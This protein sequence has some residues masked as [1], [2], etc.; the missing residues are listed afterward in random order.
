MPGI[1][2]FVGEHTEEEACTLLARMCRAL[3]DG[4]RLQTDGY[5]APGVGLGRLRFEWGPQETQPL[6]SEDGHFCLLFEGE[7]YG[8]DDRRR[9]LAA[10]GHR[11]ETGTDAEYVL[12]LYETLGERFLDELNGAFIGAIWHPRSRRLVLFNDHLGQRPLYYASVPGGLCFASGIRA[13]LE[14]PHVEPAIDPLGLAQMLTFE[15]L[16]ED[17][18]LLA[19]VRLLAPGSVLVFEDGRLESR[20][21][22]E[23]RF[24]PANPSMDPEDY[25]QGFVEHIRRA[26]HRQLSEAD[27]RRV[28][29]L[30][31]GGL[32]SR[33][34]LALLH[35]QVHELHTFTFGIPGCDDARL[36]QELAAVSRSV[37]HFSPLPPDYLLEVGQRGIRLSDG[38]QSCIHMHVLANL[39]E[40]TQ[41]VHTL[42]KGFLGD[43]ITG[44]HLD[45]ML[46]SHYPEEIVPEVLLADMD[47]VFPPEEHPHLFQPTFHR[48]VQDALL[49]SFRSAVERTPAPLLADRHNLFDLRQRQRRFILHGVELTRSRAI[50]RTPFAD[51]DFVEFMTRVP[52]GL[53]LNR[54][55]VVDMLV[56]HA[57]ELAKV[58]YSGTGF[59]LMP[60]FRDLRIRLDH[61]L[62]WRLRA[63]G[64]SWVPVRRQRPYAD[65]AHWL[66]TSL[67]AWLEETLLSSRTFERGYFQPE[68]I[69][70]LVTEHMAGVDHS[71]RLGV[72]LTLEL[73][74]R[75]SLD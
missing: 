44:G 1:V 74:H 15:Y 26:V 30:L 46:W 63:A 34:L 71:R 41:V 60:C 21:Y 70:N 10:Q 17:T 38:M 49:E 68:Y 52:P 42:F 11:F 20:E 6:W 36:A 8:Y 16:L 5:S 65:Y 75:S 12:R 69:H 64:L 72:L 19:Q 18:T 50:V 33:V 27:R 32:D 13:L 45:R 3:A 59:P 24:H 48:H 28:G 25:L 43:A 54:Q 55:L 37:H 9:A 53:R 58:P 57:P 2:G 22:Y 39:D 35:D 14:H 61:Q 66:R 47:L 73:W 23:L 4:E 67:R 29:L 40:Q 7:I 56:R 31:S 62:R 51:R